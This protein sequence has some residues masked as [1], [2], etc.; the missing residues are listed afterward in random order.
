MF[1]GQFPT[2]QYVC[3]G[4]NT[5]PISMY[6]SYVSL[7]KLQEPCCRPMS[8]Q[9]I[10]LL[11]WTSLSK[12]P[13]V[14]LWVNTYP[15]T[16]LV[17]E[18]ANAHAN[19]TISHQYFYMLMGIN[20]Y[21]HC[22]QI[23][24]LWNSMLLWASA[25]ASSLFVGMGQQPSNDHIFRYGPLHPKFPMYAYGL[26]YI[27]VPYLFLRMLCPCKLCMCCCGPIAIQNLSVHGDGNL[28]QLHPNFMFVA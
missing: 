22:I 17:A 24:C 9:I 28:S 14:L 6:E 4:S 2:T 11:L 15:S 3:G 8:I 13:D 12:C 19:S 7:S 18:D 16:I 21:P 25:H 10:W 1:A 26:I 27:Q 5:H 20:I 23:L